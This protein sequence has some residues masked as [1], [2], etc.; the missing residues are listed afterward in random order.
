MEKLMRYVLVGATLLIIG[1]VLNSVSSAYNNLGN[2]IANNCYFGE[3]SQANGSVSCTIQQEN[4]SN[5]DFFY[6][7]LLSTPSLLL[8][9]IGLII[10]VPTAVLMIYGAYH[11]RSLPPQGRQPKKSQ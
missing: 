9:L 7:S 3:F 6:A 10:L 8:I 5:G 11:S 4:Q 2:N 1:I